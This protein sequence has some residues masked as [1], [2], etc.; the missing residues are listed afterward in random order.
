M[1]RLTL[2]LFGLSFYTLIGYSQNVVVDPTFNLGSGFNN[3]VFAT[4]V[5]SDGKILA[6]GT[7]TTFNNNSVN[8]LLRLNPDGSLD[9][10]FLTN[11][12]FN[13]VS[14]IFIQND[15][16][17][18]V[19]GDYTS[20]YNT[21]IK[22]FLRVNTNGTIDTTFQSGLGPD[23]LVY[24]ISQQQ[25]GKILIG[26]G[27]HHYNG[28]IAKYLTRINVDGSLDTTFKN[29]T[30][31]FSYSGFSGSVRSIKIQP[32]G[33]FIVGGTFGSFNTIPRRFLARLNVDGSLDTTF[34]IGNGFDRPVFSVDIQQDGKIVV[35][36]NFSMFNGDTCNYI[37]RLNVNGTIDS[38]FNTRTGF[39]G[40]AVVRIVKLQADG[41]IL[42]GGEF[43]SFNG[44]AINNIAR[45][46]SNGGL[47]SSFLPDS[48]FNYTFMVQVNT[49]SI[50]SNGKIITGGRF[51]FFDSVA[52]NNLA[53]IQDTSMIVNVSELENI[54]EQ[55]TQIL[56]YPNPTNES[57]TISLPEKLKCNSVEL[58]NSMGQL[59]EVVTPKSQRVQMQI[60]GSP[61]IYLIHIRGK[62]GT[63]AKSI[64]KQ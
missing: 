17:I 35:G 44:H 33:K 37:A 30:T 25:D 63:I 62:D 8:K 38:T 54:E 29:A 1:F 22:R 60:N 5:Q 64:I 27:F 47:D 31:V 10:T 43:N 32:D 45:L 56:I 15:G 23:N 11:A 3:A 6:G 40:P 46:Q 20:S 21:Q 2:I 12:S 59:L 58:Y 50:Q 4:A 13:N 24:S 36:G 61:G 48:G 9:T 26:G 34:N 16:K 53:R 19:A 49:I 55:Q 39:N 18:L 14:V 41:K 28:I 52:V 57:F 7:F 51:S 42:A